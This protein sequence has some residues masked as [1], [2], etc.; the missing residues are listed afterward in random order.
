MAARG[1]FGKLK[2]DAVKAIAEGNT[3]DTEDERLRAQKYMHFVYGDDYGVGFEL[4]GAR[5]DGQD[6]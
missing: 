3:D 5:K 2:Y 4:H 6:D 1:R